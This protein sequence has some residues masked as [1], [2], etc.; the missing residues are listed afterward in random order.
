MASFT[1]TFSYGK[2]P[3]PCYEVSCVG[4]EA[5]R[6]HT[7]Y[8]L[9]IHHAGGCEWTV[10]RRHSELSIVHDRLCAVFGAD[11]LPAFPAKAPG[12]LGNLLGG[13]GQRDVIEQREV[14]LQ[15]YFEGVCARAEVTRT[16]CFQAAIGVVPPSP[17]MHFRVRGWQPCSD[18]SGGEESKVASAVVEMISDEQCNGSAAVV[19]G[20][21]VVAI[22]VV[23]AAPRAELMP[24]AE[25]DVPVF[26]EGPAQIDG[27]P[28]GVQVELEVCAYNAVGRSPTVSIRVLVPERGQVMAPIPPSPKFQSPK[29]NSLGLMDFCGLPSA[30]RA[31]GE[32]PK[33]EAVTGEEP[34]FEAID[35]AALKSGADRLGAPMA[36]TASSPT[37]AGRQVEWATLEMERQL[38]ELQAQKL[39]LDKERE[40]VERE[41]ADLEQRFGYLV[42]SEDHKDVIAEPSSIEAVP[43]L[44]SRHPSMEKSDAE[45][46]DGTE[47]S[48]DRE[49]L[50]RRIAEFQ[51]RVD[52]HEASQQKS[53][54][55]KLRLREELGQ[56]RKQLDEKREALL[57]QQ[58]EKETWQ[59]KEQVWDA[60][61]A[62]LR[63]RE[64]D[65]ERAETE[66][67]QEREELARSRKSLAVVQAHMLSMLER[68]S[69]DTV[70]NHR[71]DDGPLERSVSEMERDGGLVSPRIDKVWSMDWTSDAVKDARGDVSPRS[72]DRASRRASGTVVQQDLDSATAEG[73]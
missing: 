21:I 41:R 71:I 53:D 2:A 24:L 19:E 61:E 58:F 47:A 67:L 43:E 12:F 6:G 50:Q 46:G 57:Q 36:A 70:E 38:A 63:D 34:V 1:M 7:E 27:L 32:S 13:A 51:S 62:A 39:A 18:E 49:E 60:R 5:H 48:S 65:M 55:E 64:S 10:A 14:G 33:G 17:V 44:A 56:V 11:G 8:R 66:L 22:P 59:V 25:V 73:S 15:R 29:P 4:H 45:G 69:A 20:Y 28:E 35:D 68:R 72:P 37:G 31:G 52:E 40:A 9:R 42:I 16:A 26:Q 54:E 30:A 3:P 23:L